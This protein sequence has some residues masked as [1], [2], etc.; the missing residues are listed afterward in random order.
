MIGSGPEIERI[1]GS[2]E[3]VNIHFLGYQSRPQ[4]WIQ[5]FDIAILPTYFEA[6]GISILDYLKCGKP[7]IATNVG[8]IPEIIDQPKKECG[9]LV[10]LNNSGKPDVDSIVKAVLQLYRDQSFY[11][12]C[13]SNMA[14]I[15]DQFTLKEFGENYEKKFLEVINK[16]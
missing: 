11:Q 10:N 14:G 5:A 13:V 9:V 12:N 3:D 8:G 1:R 2:V 15:I 6:L 7:V 16:K 4:Y